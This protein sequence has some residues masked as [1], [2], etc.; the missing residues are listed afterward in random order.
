[1]LIRAPPESVFD[2]LTNPSITTRFWYTKSS[3][4]IAQGAE[5]VWEWEMYG[6][7][8]HVKVIEVQANRLVRFNWDGFDST[9]PTT[10]EFRIIPYHENTSYLRITET[11]FTG[12]GDT[13][14]E[15]A[16]DLTGGFTF[17]ISAL[18]AALEHDITLRVTGDAH[19][20]DLKE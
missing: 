15:R 1:M 9:K 20:F 8:T 13:Q 18:K 3:G 4:R 19:R 7:S 10:V 14:T 5:L 2:A 17:M 11:G 12:D 6:A 16:I